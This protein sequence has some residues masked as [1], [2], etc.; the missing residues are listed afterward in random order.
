MN[1]PGIQHWPKTSCQR[2][3][4][5]GF[6]VWGSFPKNNRIT[7]NNRGPEDETAILEA[8]FLKA[9][10]VWK[11]DMNIK[12]TVTCPQN[13]EFFFNLMAMNCPIGLNS[14]Q[15]SRERKQIPR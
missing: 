3:Q 2:N 11:G 14:D 5:S 15:K 13:G 10:D 8:T 9:G 4:N 12:K 7:T 6:Y 1:H